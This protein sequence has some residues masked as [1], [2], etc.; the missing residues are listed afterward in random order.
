MPNM[1]IR[2]GNREERVPIDYPPN[3]QAAKNKKAAEARERPKPVITGEVVERQGGIFTRVVKDFV[4]EDRHTI[5]E[6]IILEVMLPAAKNLILDMVNKGGERMLYGISRP[7]GR[8]GRA[9]GFYNYGGTPQAAATRVTDPRPTISRQ[10][11]SQHD[12][13]EVV[14]RERVDADEVLNGL[15]ELIDRYGSASVSDFYDLAGFTGEFTDNRWG[16][17]DLR[18]ASVRTVRGGYILDL[19][20]TVPLA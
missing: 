3:S 4:Q 19:P 14:V 5:A 17:E 6:Y 20:D 16:W 1:I 15:R 2:D 9:T 12:F 11:R 13:R 10:A 7:G 18:R 8:T